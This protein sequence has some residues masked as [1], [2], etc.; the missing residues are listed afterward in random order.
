MSALPNVTGFIPYEKGDPEIPILLR[1][2]KKAGVEVRAISMHYDPEMEGV[3]LD[4]A[5]LLV[6][7]DR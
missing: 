2:A 6:I 3:V 7:L 4:E 1:K 5:D